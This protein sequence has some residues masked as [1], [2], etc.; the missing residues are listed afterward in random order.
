MNSNRWAGDDASQEIIQEN[1]KG[2]WNE[3]KGSIPNYLG[4]G[5]DAKNSILYLFLKY[6]FWFTL[7]II[8][9]YTLVYVAHVWFFRSIENNFLTGM[10]DI[11]KVVIPLITLALGYVFGQ[12]KL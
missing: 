3:Q 1:R 10:L 9:I 4:T 7:T 12:S 2:G 11:L 6:T 5:E 8:I